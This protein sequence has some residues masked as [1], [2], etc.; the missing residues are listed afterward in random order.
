[1]PNW[2]SLPARKV[3]DKK[4]AKGCTLKGLHGAVD[5]IRT[6]T[7]VSAPPDP[8]SGAAANFATTALLRP[9]A[10]DP[11][12]DASRWLSYWIV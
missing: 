9:A 10:L 1:M 3:I 2:V 7:E 12:T 5:G 6:R 4:Y 8:K 11:P